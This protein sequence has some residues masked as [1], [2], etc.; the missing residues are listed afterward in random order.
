M[1]SIFI[2]IPDMYKSIPDS[3]TNIELTTV[4]HYTVKMLNKFKSNENRDIKIA[5]LPVH[6]NKDLLLIC[7]SLLDEIDVTK[8]KNQNEEI[9]RHIGLLFGIL[10]DRLNREVNKMTSQGKELLQKFRLNE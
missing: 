4:V 3:L 9:D 2:K 10:K 6:P 5:D 7:N 1:L 8:L